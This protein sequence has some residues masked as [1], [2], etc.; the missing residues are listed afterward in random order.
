GGDGEVPAGGGAGVLG[1]DAGVHLHQGQ[2]ACVRIRLEHPQVGDDASGAGAGQ[3]QAVA[4]SG[5]AAVADRGHE[6]DAV[7]EGARGL[8]DDDD[9]LAAGGGDLRC[10]AGAGQPHLGIRVVA[11]DGGVDVG[12][13]VDLGGA[14]ETD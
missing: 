7:H 4:V 11:D 10:A 1:A 2:L 13:P 12:V 8:P 6:V 9:H 14:Q 3:S 5:A